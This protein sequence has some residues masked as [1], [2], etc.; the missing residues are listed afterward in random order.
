MVQRGKDT[1]GGGFAGCRVWQL[2]GTWLAAGSGWQRETPQWPYSRSVQCQ[3]VVVVV[4]RCTAAWPAKK[5]NP[6]SGVRC[7]AGEGNR[8]RTV[9]YST[10]VRTVILC[11]KFGPLCASDRPRTNFFLPWYIPDSMG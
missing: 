4:V 3:L 9:L 5:Y 11:N 8:T 1:C 6:V 10:Y 2:A 7:P